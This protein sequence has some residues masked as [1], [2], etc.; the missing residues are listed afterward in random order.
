MTS[1]SHSPVLSRRTFDLS[2]PSQNLLIALIMGLMGAF[3][4]AIRGHAGANLMQP[5]PG[6]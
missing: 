5:A 4:W 1:S 3:F 6:W 2:Q